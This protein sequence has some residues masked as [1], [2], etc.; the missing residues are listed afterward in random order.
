MQ[1]RAQALAGRIGLPAATARR[2][3]GLAI[4]DAR[5]EQASQLIWIK[6]AT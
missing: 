5:R 1:A 4:D 6:V 3:I 2:V